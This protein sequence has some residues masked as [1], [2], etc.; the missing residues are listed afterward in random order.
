MPSSTR[1]QSSRNTDHPYERHRRHTKAH[2]PVVGILQCCGSPR[3]FPTCLTARVCMRRLDAAKN[4]FIVPAAVAGRH[5]AIFH[6]SSMARYALHHSTARRQ[7]HTCSLQKTPTAQHLPR[8]IVSTAYNHSA[9]QR[10]GDETAAQEARLHPSALPWIQ[11]SETTSACTRSSFPSLAPQKA[12]RNTAFHRWTE[13]F[14]ARTATYPKTT[15][16]CSVR[17]VPGKKSDGCDDLYELILCRP[18]E[19]RNFFQPA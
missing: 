2:Q 18:P 6:S 11:P 5:D 17:T 4:A 10:S 14:G 8:N 12:A 7:L 19:G 3:T 1:S 15:T 16:K 13:D 9:I